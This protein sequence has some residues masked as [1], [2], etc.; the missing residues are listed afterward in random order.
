MTELEVPL[1]VKPHPAG[2]YLITLWRKLANTRHYTDL[3]PQ[4]ISMDAIYYYFKLVDYE[5]VAPIQWE[6]DTLMLIDQVWLAEYY[7]ERQ[8]QISNPSRR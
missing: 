7:T 6:I 3:G 5:P 1:D 2:E 8:E 4:P